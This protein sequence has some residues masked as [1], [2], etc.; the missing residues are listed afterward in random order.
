MLTGTP[1]DGKGGANFMMGVRTIKGITA[2]NART[3][4]KKAEAGKWEQ[5]CLPRVRRPGAASAAACR[6]WRVP[7]KLRRFEAEQASPGRKASTESRSAREYF[8]SH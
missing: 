5:E 4:E 7:A 1:E 6:G 2:E 3:S 8:C